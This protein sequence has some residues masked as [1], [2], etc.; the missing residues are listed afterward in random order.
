VLKT[1][2]RRDMRQIE[3]IVNKLPHQNLP[4]IT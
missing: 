4:L 1:S 2:Q 3:W